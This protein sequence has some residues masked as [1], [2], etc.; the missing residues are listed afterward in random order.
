MNDLSQLQAEK[1]AA[2]WERTFQLERLL[3][4][5]PQIPTRH[6]PVLGRDKYRIAVLS[7]TLDHARDASLRDGQL[8]EGL[9]VGRKG[10]DGVVR[11]GKEEAAAVGHG[12]QHVWRVGRIRRVI[13]DLGGES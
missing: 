12:V 3:C 6:G 8:P 4:Q 7:R 13:V 2:E 10:A 9:Q 11:R 1:S 5:V